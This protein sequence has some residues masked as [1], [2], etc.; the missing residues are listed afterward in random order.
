[1][2]KPRSA[3]E[4]ITG[5]GELITDGLS[6]FLGEASGAEQEMRSYYVISQAAALVRYDIL[7]WKRNVEAESIKKTFEQ[8]TAFYLSKASVDVRTLDLN[9]FLL[10]YSNQLMLMSNLKSED[11]EKYIDEAERIYWKL[12]G[13][14]PSTL[15]ASMPMPAAATRNYARILL[16]K[17]QPQL[18][19]V[20]IFHPGARG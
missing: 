10:A 15:L 9:T 8:C 4:I 19:G 20:C 17:A 6:V 16:L 14:Q 13:G 18:P 2:R 5:I 12:R 3:S 7:A 11:I 1:M